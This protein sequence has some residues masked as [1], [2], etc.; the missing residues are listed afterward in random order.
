MK[1]T[2]RT[3]LIA[4][5]A[6][7]IGAP[8]AKKKA[9]ATESSYDV[10]VVGSGVFGSWTALELRKRGHKVALIDSYGPGNSRASSGGESRVIRMGYGADAIYTGW[11]MKSLERWSAF[12]DQVKKPLFHKD[13]V[14]WMARTEDP[15]ATASLETLTK[16]KIP[17]ERLSRQDLE[18]RYP[19]IAFGPITWA[20]L[21][22]N[23]GALMARRAVQAVA[24][25]AV[26]SGVDLL[27]G[28]VA[29]PTE[30][31]HLDAVSVGTNSVKAGTFV[32]ACGPWLQKLF[33]AV[34]GDRIFPTRQEVFYFGTPAAGD[35][36][37]APAMPVWIDFGDE[38]YGM[39]DIESKGFKVAPDKHGPAFDPDSGERII[40]PVTLTAVR[41]FVARRFPALK[42]APLVASEV[43]QYENTSN[44]DFLVDRHPDLEN[45]WLVGGGSG[46]GFKHGP[47]LGE[48]VADQVDGK[49]AAE[50]RFSLATKATTQK[51]S[52]H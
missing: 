52:V 10:A 36:F 51:R 37:R 29:T 30:R 45:V 50:P 35:A 5:G 22:P 12:F 32:F 3:F 40:T 26:R 43:C 39:P 8:L 6:G 46:H 34:L 4:A 18:A 16:L 14:L 25:E 7:A 41:E 48:Y 33:P 31:K 47:A 49:G 20:I 38:M 15:I 2:R 17:H 44:G 21:E 9:N 27:R 11:A 23:S 1:T 19:Q 28:P 13:G 24:E 42:N